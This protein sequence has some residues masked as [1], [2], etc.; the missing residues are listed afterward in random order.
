MFST[1][2]TITLF[3][4]RT[5]RNTSHGAQLFIS[6]LVFVSLGFRDAG[7]AAPANSELPKRLKRADSFLG[8]HFDFHAGPDCTEV[9]KNTT[10]AMVERIIDLIGP[11]YIQTDCKGH[12]G[13]SSYPT[14]VGNQ[15]PG[16]VGDP[17]RVWRDVTARRGVSLYMHY[18]GV[19]DSEAIAKHPSWGA[20]NADG[21]TNRNATSFYS[22][23]ADQL[24]IPQLRELAGEYGV[25][26]AWID[27]ECW[28]SVADYGAAALKAFGETTGIRNVPRKPGEPD[29]IEFLQFNRDAFRKY[30][31]YYITEVKKTHPSFELCSNWAYTDHMAEPVKAPVDFISGDY[32]PE[33]SVNSARLSGR[34]LVRQGK[35]WDLMAWS[36]TRTKGKEGRTQKSAVQ[37][38]REAAVVLAL[39]GGFQAYFKQKRD[40]SI[41]DEQMPIMAEVAKFCRARQ[42]IC[43]RAEPVP[44]VALLLS[45]AGHYRRINGLFN[46]DLSR[47]SGTLQALLENQYSVEVVGEHHLTGLLSDYP[48]VVVPEWEFLDPK[49]KEDLVSYV[50]NGGNLLLIGAATAKLFGNELGEAF[51]HEFKSATA[52]RLVFNGEQMP[53]KGLLHLAKLSPPIKIFGTL[54]PTNETARAS[55]PAASLRP[56]GKG[57]I[58]AVYFS[59]GSSYLD[60][61]NQTARRFLNDAVRQLFPKP[62]VQVQGSSDVDV[63]ANRMAGKL[64]IH[65]VNTAGPHADKQTPVFDSIPPVGPLQMTIRHEKKPARV[66][67]QPGG[68]PLAHRFADGLISVTIPPVAIH[69]IVVVE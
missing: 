29:W 26:G 11:D 34:Y 13:F 46:R 65:L 1:A 55:S 62:L 47:V 25:D 63:V 58:A 36:F 22:P 45:T 6:L 3:P 10:P 33:D 37:L 57:K 9:G 23:Y 60:S 51:E 5:K 7:R 44:Q 12:R 4:M 64:A 35:P 56:L 53:L 14:K 66:T 32:S 8:I 40:G 49:F 19:W 61:R 41:Y 50:R 43:H 16:F 17:L 21:S 59:L 48:L 18:S 31:R 38:Q 27:G 67:L 24:L 42:A 30:L 15:A 39:G 69:S 28:A 2:H 54:Q 20:I 68:E 52:H